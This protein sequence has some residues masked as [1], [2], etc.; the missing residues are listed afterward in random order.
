MFFNKGTQ[1]KSPKVKLPQM[2]INVNNIIF[3]N[4]GIVFTFLRY[5]SII[6]FAKD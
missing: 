2:E 4:I 1:V 5:L 3:K 6:C